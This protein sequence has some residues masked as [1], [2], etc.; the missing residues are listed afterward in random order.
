MTESNFGYEKISNKE[1]SSR[2]RGIFNK[3][4]NKY[5]L[6]NDFMSLGMQR[7]WKKTFISSIK[8]VKNEDQIVIDLAGG[9]GDIAFKFLE[10]FPKN[11]FVNI[12]DINQEMLNEGRKVSVR[13]NLL[14]NCNFI[15]SPGESIALR[16]NY[17]DILTIAF[18]IRNVSD[19]KKCLEECFRVLKPGGIFI[20]MEFSMPKD[21]MLRNLYDIWSYG[22]IPK[23]GKLI[24]GDETPY[25]YLVD[26][27][28]TFPNPEE[29][30][31]MIIKAG[32]ISNTIKQLTGNIVCIYRAEKP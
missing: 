5:D 23:L 28:R 8:S 16:S 25:R 31:D 13:N 19:R 29:F 4:A 20:C 6:M 17:A 21:I 11:N 10:K 7:L 26:S 30:N 32:F 27:I 15:C 1:H 9:T 3:V 24:V 12:V 18:G 14:S 2:V 22:F